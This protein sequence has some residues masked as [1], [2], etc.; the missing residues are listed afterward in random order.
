MA[1]V[2]LMDK[3]RF[4]ARLL[5][6]MCLIALFQ[7]VCSESLIYQVTHPTLADTVKLLTLPG[8]V[9]SVFLGI[10]ALLVYIYLRP[11][12]GFLGAVGR[13]DELEAKT[14]RSIQNRALNFPYFMAVLAYPFYMVGSPVATWIICSKLGWPTDLVY[15]GLLG[16]TICS[17]LATPLAVYGYAWQVQPVLDLTVRAG[18]GDPARSAGQRI[19]VML[20]LVMTVLC[21]VV[22]CTGYTLVVGYKQNDSLL[23]NMARMEQLLPPEARS[24][25]IREAPRTAAP[26]AKSSEFFGAGPGRSL[27]YHAA[28]IVTAALIALLLSMAAGMNIT[29]PLRV[30]IR[31]AHRAREG[32]YKE[33]VRLVSN[34]ELGELGQAFNQMTETITRQLH[35]MQAVVDSLKSGVQSID[36][37]VNT[38]VAVSRQQSAGATSQ[39][40][41]LQQTSS[42]S[43]EIASTAKE[44]EER[45]KLMDAAASSTF[46]SSQEGKQKLERSREEFHAITAQMDAI[47]RAMTELEV[48]FRETYTI[49]ALIKDM[50]EK[51][52]ILSLNASIEAAGAGLEG[53]RFMVV[54]EETRLLATKSADAV[55]QIKD[56]VNVIQ[57]ATVESIQVTEQGKAKVVSG[58]RTIESALETLKAIASFAESTFSAVKE[59][60][61]STAQQ[62]RASEQLAG[63]VGEIYEVSRRVEKGA[64]EISS[65]INSLKS[66]AESLRKTVAE[67]SDAKM[68]GAGG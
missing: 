51:T 63:S 44:I 53:R 48:R 7:V 30:L 31:A 14:I 28:V 10:F 23:A 11:V 56:L 20:K 1:D 52:E 39:A 32:D 55:K 4:M 15:Y 46:S 36:D 58:G 3:P 41:A 2:G 18:K 27:V 67:G 9:V 42:I 22:G 45:A 64:Q 35:S 61:G 49:V 57:Q 25:L 68:E 12:L 50:A 65:S 40:S 33:P 29:L 17:L 5:S 38:I 19:P 60:T 62:T 43:K 8:P 26:G 54:A 24:N 59:I 66:F 16:G 6:V 21:L 13:G 34:D 47:Q 37:T